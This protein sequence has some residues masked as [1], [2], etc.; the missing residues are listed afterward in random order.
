MDLLY[1][2]ISLLCLI[3]M[4]FYIRRKKTYIKDR[5]GNTEIVSPLDTAMI[6]KAYI[7]IGF[8]ILMV[9]YFIFME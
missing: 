2:G 6:T 1:S 3:T 4:I 8:L 5:E 7:V 9:F